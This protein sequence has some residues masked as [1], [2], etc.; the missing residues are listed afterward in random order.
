VDDRPRVTLGKRRRG[1]HGLGRRG[2]AEAGVY[3]D[4]RRQRQRRRDRLRGLRDVER[5]RGV[6]RVLAVASDVVDRCTDV[7]PDA[8]MHAVGAHS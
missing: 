3:A 1:D 8:D 6:V 4:R 7:R 2:A 5:Q